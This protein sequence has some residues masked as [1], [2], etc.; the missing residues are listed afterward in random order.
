MLINGKKVAEIVDAELFQ[1]GID[2]PTYLDS[3]EQQYHIE[4]RMAEDIIY[5]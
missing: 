3:L 5:M 4:K 1:K 2:L